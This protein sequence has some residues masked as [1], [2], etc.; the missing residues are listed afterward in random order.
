M[1]RARDAA[2]S[3]ASAL[4]GAGGRQAISRRLRQPS[5]MRWGRRHYIT[6][7]AHGF[8]AYFVSIASHFPA[9]AG[10]YGFKL[11]KMLAAGLIFHH[12][13]VHANIHFYSCRLMRRRQI[14]H[15]HSLPSMITL[16]YHAPCPEHDDDAFHYRHAAFPHTIPTASSASAI[17][18]VT[19]RLR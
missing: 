10:R 5:P 16:I 13:A 14:T 2:A 7:R 19:L 6:P 17:P 9:R 12:A 4:I 1:K 3:S 15:G 8:A 18:V 11:F